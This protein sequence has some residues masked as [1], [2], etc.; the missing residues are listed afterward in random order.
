MKDNTINNVCFTQDKNKEI[1]EALMNAQQEFPEIKKNCQVAFNKV[2]FKYADLHSILAAVKKPL[3][4]HG[5]CVTQR[6]LP[7]PESSVVLQTDLLHRSGEMIQSSYAFKMPA[8][9]KQFGSLLTYGRRYQLAA[10]LGVCA[11][12]D[13][14]A[15]AFDKPKSGVKNPNSG[16]RRITEA[17]RKRLFAIMN[18]Q[19]INQEVFKDYL[20]KNYKIESSKEIL[21]KDYESIVNYV[22]GK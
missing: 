9:I 7:G 19:E 2:N 16:D 14:D 21:M 18:K 22:E 5:L 6:M 1:N 3:A 8:D 17:Q 11:D 12:E 13:K 20:K 4:K 15:V 10:I